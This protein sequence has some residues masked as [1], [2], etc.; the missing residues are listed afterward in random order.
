MVMMNEIKRRRK[1]GDGFPELEQF[2]AQNGRARMAGI[3]KRF[4]DP[5]FVDDVIQESLTSIWLSRH[6][7]D[8]SKGAFEAW[9]STIV[10]RCAL[11]I[12]GR[13]AWKLAAGEIDDE[14]E[15]GEPTIPL[16]NNE[17]ET[18]QFL[19]I[20]G[21]I[22]QGEHHSDMILLRDLFSSGKPR[23]VVM[24]EHGLGSDE[25]LRQRLHRAREAFLEKLRRVATDSE[26]SILASGSAT[27]DD[28]ERIIL[29]RAEQAQAL[30]EMS[31]TLRRF[32]HVARARSQRQSS[33][34]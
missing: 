1:T 4:C 7:Y 2:L 3:A 28:W 30:D 26:V 19:R 11:R 20:V 25:A 16:P 5:T 13:S 17:E 15:G 33:S 31:R 10:R 12:G 8:S 32:A 6:Q 23:S 9:I 27:Y 24:V 21:A 34:V 29:H 14:L 22:L 18:A